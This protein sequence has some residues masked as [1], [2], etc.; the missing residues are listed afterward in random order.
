[1]A[2]ASININDEIKRKLRIKNEV[3]L[4]GA[5]AKAADRLDFIVSSEENYLAALFSG[6]EWTFLKS[7]SSNLSFLSASSIPDLLLNSVDKAGEAFAQE[8]GMNKQE[9]L[10][11]LK[12]LTAAQFISLIDLIERAS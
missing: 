1:M 5:I 9:L 8:F 2:R 12:D 3:G 11:K 4:S 7:I 10:L 6:E